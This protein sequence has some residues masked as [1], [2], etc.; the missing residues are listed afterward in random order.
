MTETEKITSEVVHHMVRIREIG[1]CCMPWI[2]GYVIQ[3]FCSPVAMDAKQIDVHVQITTLD[4]REGCKDYAFGSVCLSVCLSVRTCNSKTI[5]PIDLDS[6]YTI[7][8]HSK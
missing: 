3:C 8:S 6:V 2:A 4:P 7:L 1:A 5:A